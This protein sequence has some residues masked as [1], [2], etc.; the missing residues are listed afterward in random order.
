MPS[1][2]QTMTP[3]TMTQTITMPVFLRVSAREGQA[4][5]FSSAFSSRKK[6]PMRLPMPGFLSL[7]ALALSYLGLWALGS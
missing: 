6:R 7:S 3:T 5:F 2:I 1:K 4:T